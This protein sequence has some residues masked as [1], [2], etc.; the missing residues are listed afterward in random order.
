MTYRL[1]SYLLAVYYIDAFILSRKNKN[2]IIRLTKK[3]GYSIFFDRSIN[4]YLLIF[5]CGISTG[6]KEL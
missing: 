3:R 2:Q 6:V 4:R 1:V 5:L